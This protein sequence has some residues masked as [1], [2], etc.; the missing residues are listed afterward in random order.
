MSP[1][2]PDVCD[3][4]AVHVEP[5]KRH[6]KK[7]SNSTKDVVYS[8]DDVKMA[9]KE[10]MRLIIFQGSVYNVMNWAKHHPGGAR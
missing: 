1:M 6:V 5:L 7:F 9:V 3:A 10:G 2:P 8:E 4:P